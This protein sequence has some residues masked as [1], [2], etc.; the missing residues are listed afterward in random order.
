MDRLRPNFVY[1]LS[2][3]RSTLVLKI[4]VFRKF[5]TE[6][7]PLIDVRI[8]FFLRTN[9]HSKTK[10]YMLII[11]DKINIGIVNS[12]FFANLQQSYGP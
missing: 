3:T 8:W 6:L 7:W 11:I 2:L 9:Q 10:V 5:A 4:F 12:C 1:T